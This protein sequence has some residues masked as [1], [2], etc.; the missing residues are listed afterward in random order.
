MKLSQKLTGAFV[1]LVLLT[2]IVGGVGI[3]NMA[4]INANTEEIATSWLPSVKVLG[5]MRATANQLRR[6]EADH[7]M[8]STE[9]ERGAAE[10]RIANAKASLAKLEA[11][12]QPLITSPQERAL[13]EDYRKAADAYLAVQDRLLR[14]SQA[15]EAQATASRAL[16]RG[17]SRQAFN[18]VVDQLGKL[19]DLN[20]RGSVGAASAA[21]SSYGASRWT[22]VGLLLVAMVMA[23]ALTLA[24]LR[25][26][27]GTLGGEP[28][29]ARRLAQ[30][31]AQG[32][33]DS[34]IVVRNGDTTSLMAAIHAMQSGLAQV[35][36]VVRAGA[37]SV[38]SAS[39]QIAHGNHDL[40]QRTEEQASALQQT[41]ASME[42]LGSTVQQNADNA[43]QADQLAQ[44]ASQVATGGGSVVSQVV[45]TMKGIHESSRRIADIIG[46]IDGI[47]FQTNI[48]ALNAAVEAARAGEQGRGFAVVA[49]EVRNLAGRA[50]EAAREI[51]SLI[52][53]SVE[54]VEQGTA[55]VDRA[56]STMTEV[57][58]S[59]RRVT[60]IVGEI[61]AASTE[62]NSGVAQIGQAVSQMD[63]TTQQNAALVEEMAAA[64]TSLNLQAQQ[65][66]EAV[67]V[68]KLAPGQAAATARPAAP[69]TPRRPPAT[70]I[71]PREADAHGW[72]HT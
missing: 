41:A 20:D 14:S 42:E 38:A 48:L 36:A 70:G 43:R 4:R 44:N 30:A 55:L 63:Q 62:Q 60:D 27:L 12:Y 57:V 16:F 26:V 17:E 40:S 59:I 51:K 1:S 61:S 49:G 31:V 29:E 39:S 37:E 28:A 33:L 46:V 56:G 58:G 25:D 19:V 8:S 7:L 34:E 11:S 50:A 24:L 3:Y 47:A 5:D 15:G 53:A 35:V 6:G 54:R 22:M 68:F 52:T 23:A 32:H 71:S 65:L 13:Y 45:D 9:A 66:V 72:V 69:S 18:G 10:T 2:L 21:A 64:A 67:A